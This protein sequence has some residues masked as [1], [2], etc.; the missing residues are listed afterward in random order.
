MTDTRITISTILK[1][2]EFCM[3]NLSVE[4]FLAFKTYFE[5]K[6]GLSECVE[7]NLTQ[8]ELEGFSDK[9]HSATFV[10]EHSQITCVVNLHPKSIN[11]Y[12][13]N[14]ELVNLLKSL[15]LDAIKNIETDQLMI[16]NN[17]GPMPPKLNFTQT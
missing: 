11:Y 8:C 9:T 14:F 4:A 6:P 2:P 10:D 7:K 17:F 16:N 1:L 5:Q 12:L 15:M 3:L 13:G